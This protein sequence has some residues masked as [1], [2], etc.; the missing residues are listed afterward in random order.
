MIKNSRGFLLVSVLLIT[1]I[2]LSLGLTFL[3]KRSIQYRRA[4]FAEQAAM[5]RA[6]AE[7]GMEDALTKFQR[8]LEFPPLSKDQNSF[9]YSEEV[10][11]GGTY[12]GAYRVTLDGSRRFP[13]YSIWTINVQGESGP[14]PMRPVAARTLR[15]EFDVSRHARNDPGPFALNDPATNLFYYKIINFQDLGGL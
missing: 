1:M 7:S 6:L 14:N 11:V 12:S 4:A 2:L 8:D 9:S 5:A 10:T 13:P 3:S 15:A